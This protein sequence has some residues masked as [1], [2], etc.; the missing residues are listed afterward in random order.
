MRAESL[1][2]PIVFFHL[3]SI[4]MFRM[5]SLIYLTKCNFNRFS[6]C[7]FNNVALAAKYALDA[8]RL[9]RILIVDWDVHHG[10][11]TQRFFYEDPRYE[12]WYINSTQF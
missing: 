9:R 7:F 6:Y 2:H 11:G 1:L 12:F 8:L 3:L 10:Q 4:P 5:S